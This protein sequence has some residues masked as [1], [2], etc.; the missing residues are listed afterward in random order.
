METDA[1]PCTVASTLDLSKLPLR[2]G[3]SIQKT[4]LGMFVNSFETSSEGWKQVYDSARHYICQ[5]SKLP[6]RD[7]NGATRGRE[8]GEPELSKLPLRDGNF[9]WGSY[10][11]NKK[12]FRNFL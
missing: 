5:L 8:R 10:S 9:R 4:T 1:V 11:R 7:G 2:D 6:L 3:N 12:I